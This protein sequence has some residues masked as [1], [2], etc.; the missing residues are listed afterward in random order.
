MANVE[1]ETCSWYCRHSITTFVN[2][3][4]FWLIDIFY[5]FVLNKHNGDDSPQ[6]LY[7]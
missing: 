2:T 4:V 5:D 6:S 7:G 3:V 1:A